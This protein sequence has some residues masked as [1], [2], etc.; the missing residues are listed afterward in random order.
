[1]NPTPKTILEQEMLFAIVK[2]RYG[3]L[4]TDDQ[5]AEVRRSVLTMRSFTQP[6]RNTKLT[7]DI[8]PFSTF[9]PYRADPVE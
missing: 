4:L 9:H 2:E 1:M 5:L 8:E 7:N 6:L 3:Y